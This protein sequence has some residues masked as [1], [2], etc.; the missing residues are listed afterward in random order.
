MPPRELYYHLA[1]G[2][3]LLQNYSLARGYADEL[4]KLEPSN[5]QALG[6]RALVEHRVEQ[7]GLVGMALLVLLFATLVARGFRWKGIN[8]RHDDRLS[9]KELLDAPREVV[10]SD[11]PARIVGCRFRGPMDVGQRVDVRVVP[12]RLPERRHV[13]VEAFAHA[14]LRV[15]DLAI[16]GAGGHIDE[17]G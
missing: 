3:L 5:A 7:D 14:A 6:L 17:P 11:H 4:L 1:L 15:F 10:G 8:R 16:D 13:Q 9:S 2:H 12:C